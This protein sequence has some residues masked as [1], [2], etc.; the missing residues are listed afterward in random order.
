[1]CVVSLLKS[2]AYALS[3]K[4]I[5]H[6]NAGVL[7]FFQQ[8]SKQNPVFLIQ[9]KKIEIFLLTLFLLF[10]LFRLF[11]LFFF[12]GRLFLRSLEHIAEVRVF[13]LIAM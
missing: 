6:F 10:A 1:M 8:I 12:T 3:N 5:R 4:T 11:G 7:N 13:L 2:T 9:N